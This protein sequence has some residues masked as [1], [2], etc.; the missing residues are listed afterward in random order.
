MILPAGRFR[1]LTKVL[2]I[3]CVDVIVRDGRGR[4]LLIKRLKEPMK[5]RWWVIGGRVYKGE[6]LTKAA[7]RKVLEETGVE[8]EI[9]A[10]VGYYESLSEKTDQG[11]RFRRHSVSV[12]FLA[13]MTSTP[14][15]VLDGQ[16]AS[17]RLSKTLPR[18]FRFVP[19]D[20]ISAVRQN[21]L[22]R[23]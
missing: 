9:L 23:R 10:S 13:K 14:R 8:V 11:N 3:L 5:G 15:V 16:S 19:F 20:K 17:W 12:V 22:S 4:I 18:E 1:A 2:P 6:T 7:R 21:S